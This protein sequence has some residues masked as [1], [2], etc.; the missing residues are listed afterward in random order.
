MDLHH[1]AEI[2]A[3]YT[4]GPVE[5]HPKWST[6]TKN[7]IKMEKSGGTDRAIEEAVF[8]STENH[9]QILER[10]CGTYAEVQINI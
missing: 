9:Q 1:Q 2:K 6:G 8:S 7:E 5:Q 3:K 4:R 10:S